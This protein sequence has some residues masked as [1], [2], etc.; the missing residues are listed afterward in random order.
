MREIK[1]QYGYNRRN[2]CRIYL[3]MMRWFIE[4]SYVIDP[5]EIQ[6]TN[7]VRDLDNPYAE[8]FNVFI[9]IKVRACGFGM[10]FYLHQPFI[11]FDCYTCNKVAYPERVSTLKVACIHARRLIWNER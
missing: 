11:R 2:Y 3:S 5:A 10:T 1:A 8:S 6:I 4:L 9:E 7:L